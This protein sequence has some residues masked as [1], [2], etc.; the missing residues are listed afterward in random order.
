MIKN[1]LKIALRILVRQKS[2]SVINILGLSVGMAGFILISLWV[3]DELN[4]DKFHNNVDRLYLVGQDQYFDTE[5][6]SVRNTP[7]AFKEAVASEVP[8]VELATRFCN[9][10]SLQVNIGPD[11]FI[12]S[13]EFVDPE[14]LEMF[15][16][17]FIAGDPTTALNDKFSAVISE[18]MAKKYFGDEDPLGQT[19]KLE[20]E[21]NFQITGVFT[22][23][24]ANSFLKPNI[25]V[26]F[27]FTKDLGY[28]VGWG[29]NWLNTFV[30]LNEGASMEAVNDKIF[31]R[32]SKEFE[33]TSELFL[34]PF[35][36]IHL[37]TFHYKGGAIETVYIFGSIA[38]FIIVI[39]C[40][41][42]MN[43]STA[44]ATKRAKE[45]G[46]R[47][48]VG[49]ERRNV[50]FQ[51]LG[52]SLLISFLSLDI[53]IILVELFTPMFNTVALKELGLDYGSIGTI[54]M[55]LALCL[56]TGL[57]A[58]SYPAFY[59][60]GFNPT[61]VLKSAEK[62][63]TSSVLRKILVVF[64]FTLSVV[65]IVSTIIIGRQLAYIQNFDLGINKDNIVY[66]TVKG[67]VSSK[68]EI[69]K[70]EMG[71]IS[72]IESATFAR[73]FPTR[74]Y[75]N[76][77]GYNWEGKDPESNI[78]ISFT[79]IDEDFSA[80]FEPTLIEGRFLNHEM[81]DSTAN[82]MI[83][84]TF[85]DMIA[86]DTKEGQ[87]ISNGNFRATVVGVFED[88]IYTDL[89]RE[90][91][92]LALSYSA[93]NQFLFMKISGDLPTAVAS[94]E[95]VH[96]SIFP[97][98]PITV[99][100]FE[101]SFNRD[102]RQEQ[103]SSQIFMTFAILAVVISCL[104]L[105][106]LSLFMAEQKKKEVGI[107]KAMG[108]SSGGLVI[109]MSMDFTKWV[110]VAN[111]IGWPVAYYFMKDWLSGFAYHTELSI[112]VF[113]LALVISFVVALVTVMYQS[114]KTASGNPIESLHYE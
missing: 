108:A 57:L 92:P 24:P 42:F 16:F 34:H 98:D 52:E 97:D 22:D 91:G 82:I 26:P 60:S 94:I 73:H 69:L 114:Y 67:D 23:P 30:L 89:N 9:Y 99:R 27:T 50:L 96:K 49:A 35:G 112:W 65:L 107:R 103:R 109:K 4:Y 12:E 53:A 66:F 15:T 86:G 74:I 78:L 80:T 19:L 10:I 29:S 76:G 64:Q 83:N 79:S 95:E 40:V 48:A 85:A 44:R 13:I 41:N 28:P 111:V 54:P 1:Y 110:V 3:M 100:Y 21:H 77:G 7:E 70:R 14:F 11:S 105:Y 62:T 58:G 93:T 46:V 5:V 81:D 104:G 39:A 113:V 38:L 101:D 102:Y 6:F 45:I 51:F 61:K 72:G 87:V 18:E 56:I 36:D 37:H 63:G 47:K 55:L 31:D 59:L 17:P 88:F 75:S 8:E 20:N 25:L 33:T 84:K 2:F 90:V 71:K 106:G 43:L 68:A 32:L